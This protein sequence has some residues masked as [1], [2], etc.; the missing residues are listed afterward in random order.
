MALPPHA[1]RYRWLLRLLPRT[2]RDEWERDLVADWREQEHATARPTAFWRRAI[3]DTIGVGLR[4]YVV[5]AA[6]NLGVA[7]RRLRRAPAFTAAAVLT[8]ALGIGATTGV[9]ALVDAV[10][11]RPLPW[12]APDRVG[13]VWAVRPDGPP[14]W[15]SMPELDDLPALSPGL[16]AVAGVTDVRLA[17]AAAGGANSEEVQGLA[18]SHGLLRLLGVAPA[19]GRDFTR[20]DDRPEAAPVVLLSDAIWRSRYG[21]DA[22]IVGKS[23]TLDEHAFRVVGVLPARFSLLPP[24]SVLPEHVDLLVPLEP[25]AASRQRSVRFLHV[26]AR[27]RPGA[28]FA[29]VD[30]ELRARGAVLTRGFADTY[31]GGG[32]TFTIGSFERDVLRQARSALGLLSALVV[33]VLALACVNVAHLIVARQDARRRDLAVRT[34]LGASGAQLAGEQLAETGL[35]AAAAGGL[36]LILAAAIPPALRAIDPGALP[37]LADASIDPRVLVFAGALIAATAL[38]AAAASLVAR[39][40]LVAETTATSRSGGRTRAGARLARALVVLQT[41]G[42][43]TILVAAVFLTDA[44]LRLQQV[45]L[46]VRA[47]GLVTARVSLTPRYP[48]GPQAARF[49]ERATEALAARPGVAGA[50]AISQLPLSGALLGSSFVDTARGPDARVDVD[51]RAV[52]PAWFG[53]AGTPLVA[54]RGFG[55]GDVAGAPRVAIVDET[56]ARR[57]VPGGGSAI[58]RRIRWIRQPDVD[59]EIVGV[60]RAVRHRG[61][62]DAPMPTVYRPLAQYPRWSMFLAARVAPG[63]T[64]THADVQA[65]V[66]AIDPTQ[67]VADVAAMPARVA[68]SMARPRSSTWL[69]AALAAVALVLATVGVY[70]VLSVGV[71]A[72]RREFGVR[73][74]IGARPRAVL[75]RVLG[76]G[77]SLTAAGI[78]VGTA[79]G[80]G[81]ISLAR[82][83]MP[84]AQASVAA[85]CAAAALVVLGCAAAALW[86][87]ARRA[88]AVDPRM[89]L[90]A[91]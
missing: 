17:L 8:L 64:L 1:R 61:A 55:P 36:G 91:D 59:V 2:F 71:A 83:A 73:L 68:R 88:S 58:G 29:G 15:L 80:I 37:R 75:A 9:F 25:A 74:A 87:P 48:D 31:P 85:A 20:D 62:T 66:G 34:A 22:G 16:A 13:L 54:G 3:V 57:L 70:G 38:S 60:V 81:V 65:A 78:A 82:A 6:R 67:A 28:T 27:L 7:A 86:V 39:R 5:A 35:I 53:V 63:Q 45:E 52:T 72:R 79:G 14:T 24:T 30:A 46:G 49:F 10:L 84:A 50:A 56:L 26:L 76:E 40:W 23:I 12:T 44:L 69:A 4:E 41:A 33:L 43:T 51:L 42:A 18:V 21:A 32:W 47:E 77:V 11:L 90:Q 19:L 89:A